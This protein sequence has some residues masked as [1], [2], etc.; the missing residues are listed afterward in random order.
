MREWN[1]KAGRCMAAVPGEHF[2]VLRRF[3][4]LDP[5][6]ERSLQ[7]LGHAARQHD[8]GPQGERPHHQGGG[9]EGAL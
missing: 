3:R 9:A 8:L 5:H 6:H 4:A 2:R 7:V 1:A